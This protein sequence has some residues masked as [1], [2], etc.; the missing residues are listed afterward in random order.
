MGDAEKAIVVFDIT[1]KGKKSRVLATVRVESH[2]VQ[3]FQRVITITAPDGTVIAQCTKAARAGDTV[4]RNLAK[5]DPSTFTVG[6]SS[7][8]Y[9]T[10]HPASDASMEEARTGVGANGGCRKRGQRRTR[11]VGS[12]HKWAGSEKNSR[13]VSDPTCDPSRSSVR[14]S[15]GCRPGFL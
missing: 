9:A 7:E 12:K 1:E 14:P 15:Q 2:D 8:P 5:D 10:Y 13:F 3:H 4:D 11:M 6:G